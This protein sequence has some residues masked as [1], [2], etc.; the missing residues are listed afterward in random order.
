M[1][2]LGSIVNT[3][4][5]FTGHGKLYLQVFFAVM[6]ILVLVIVLVLVLACPV[7][8]NVTASFFDDSI[9][10]DGAEASTNCCG[11]TLSCTSA[12][13]TSSASSTISSSTSDNEGDPLSIASDLICRK[14]SLMWVRVSQIKP[15]NCFKLHPT[16]M[17]SKH[18]TI[19]V[20]DSLYRGA[21]KN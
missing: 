4:A 19:P 12:S 3:H 20:P 11:K 9:G 18:S 6:L 13:S 16:S 2:H 5:P 7:L 10:A 21:S 14:V 17:I 1:R 15:S 8:V